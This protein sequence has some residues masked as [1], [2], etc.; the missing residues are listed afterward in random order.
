MPKGLI[1][2]VAFLLL[3]G[4]HTIKTRLQPNILSEKWLLQI[5]VHSINMDTV[6]I[7]KFAENKMKIKYVKILLVTYLDEDSGTPNHVNITKDTEDA[8]L[9][10]VLS[11]I[12]RVGLI[13]HLNF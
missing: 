12:L 1:F 9:I 5:S 4:K 7:K 2:P 8:S 3:D 13:I 10:R 6:N 11:C